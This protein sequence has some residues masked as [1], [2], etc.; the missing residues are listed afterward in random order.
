MPSTLH[1]TNYTTDRRV[2]AIRAVRIARCDLGESLEA[3]TLHSAQNVIDTLRSSGEPQ[4]VGQH[5]DP[6]RVKAALRVLTEHGCEGELNLIVEHHE[7]GAE[8]DDDTVV[9]LRAVPDDPDAIPV[10]DLDVA[11]STL[12]L[13]AL[14][15][16]NPA[17]ARAAAGSFLLAQGP[18]IWAEVQELLHV[19]FPTPSDPSGAG[20]YRYD[21]DSA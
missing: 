2:S 11:S 12:I 13:M 15:Q 17:Y 18:E 3:C 9:P 14:C 16:G 6:E 10:V 5:D 1:I 19:T 20:V 21:G 7:T 4:F 8:L